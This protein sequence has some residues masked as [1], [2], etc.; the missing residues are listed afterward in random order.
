MI[1]ISVLRS[2]SVL[3]VAATATAAGLVLSCGA[4]SVAAANPS[5]FLLG[6]SASHPDSCYVGLMDS[7]L[8]GSTP[9][10]VAAEV[11]VN[12]LV[13]HV[14]CTGWVE[15]SFRST[16]RWTV[17]SAKVSVPA[18]A[19]LEVI[20]NTGLVYDGQK[21]KARACVQAAGSSA[22]SCTSAV[23]LAP[24]SG[25]ATSPA[26]SAS[27]L[28][29]SAYVVRVSFTKAH[30]GACYAVMAS[31]TTTKKPGTKVVSVLQSQREPCTAWIQT[32]ANK[33][34][35]WT[36]VSPVV[37]FRDPSGSTFA[38]A[39]T[40]HYADN[41]GHL[42]QVCVKDMVSKKVNCSGGWLPRCQP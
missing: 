33:G 6:P 32:T 31:S 9:A 39:F 29:R 4:S 27:Y 41:P 11:I 10:D 19:A 20:A 23:T 26:L 22:V 38:V 18:V 13:R 16:T 24:G 14:T 15:R 42:A 7:R 25:T 1:T 35:T 21:Y 2:I 28:R 40:A 30:G 5:G 36:T 17:A 3:A 37:S 8:S 12:H 34:R